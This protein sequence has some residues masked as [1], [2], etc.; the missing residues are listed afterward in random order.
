MHAC[1]RVRILGLSTE[2]ADLACSKISSAPVILATDSRRIKSGVGKGENKSGS[3][4][5]R[6]GGGLAPAKM[7]AQPK[8]GKYDRKLTNS[9]HSKPA[10]SFCSNHCYEKNLHARSLGGCVARFT[11][12]FDGAAFRLYKPACQ[13]R[14]MGGRNCHLRGRCFRSRSLRLPMAAQWEEPFQRHNC[15]GSRRRNHAERPF[16]RHK[17]E[18]VRPIRCGGGRAGKHFHCRHRKQ[19]RSPSRP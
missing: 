13:P 4:G 10:D 19:P 3:A 12:A 9:S 1:Y 18:P 14:R 7:P 17:F 6:H 16:G 15:N 5:L 2:K 11:R 8:R